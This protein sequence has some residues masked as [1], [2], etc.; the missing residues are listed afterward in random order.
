M[1]VWG[2]RRLSDCQSEGSRRLSGCQAMSCYDCGNLSPIRRRGGTTPLHERWCL[3]RISSAHADWRCHRYSITK[4]VAL[5][6]AAT[7]AAT[8]Y[9]YQHAQALTYNQTASRGQ[10]PDAYCHAC[11]NLSPR[12]RSKVLACQQPTRRS[13]HEPRRRPGST[14][15]QHHSCSWMHGCKNLSGCRPKHHTTVTTHDTLV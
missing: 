4:H 10:V 13:L 3:R 12:R 9:G 11:C 7:I 6:L 1:S 5:M 2:S 14:S 8:C 15:M